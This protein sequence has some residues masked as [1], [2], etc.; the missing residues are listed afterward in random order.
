LEGLLFYWLKIM[1]LR[2]RLAGYFRDRDR[3][4]VL[5]LLAAVCMLYLPFLGSPFVFDDV[6]FFSGGKALQFAHAGFHFDL[7]WVSYATLGW[8]AQLFSDVLPHFFRL[9]NLLIHAANAILLFYFLR[10]L[11]TATIHEVKPSVIAWGGWFG[12]LLFAVNPVAVYATGY[13]VE[14]SIL[15]ATFFSL[16]MLLLYLRGLLTGQVRW[17]VLAVVAYFLAVFSKEHS[18]MMPAVLAALTIL[19][20]R[21][22][23][24]SPHMLWVTW[25]GFLSIAILIILRVKGIWGMPYEPMAASLFEQQRIGGG[26]PMLH[27]LSLLTQAG[28]YFKYLLLWLLPNPAWMS[29]DMREPFI[30]SLGA[31]QG[32]LKIACFILYGI[33]GA[34]LLFRGGIRGLMGF[35]LLYPWLQFLLEFSTIRVQEPFVLYRSYLWMPGLMLLV[36]LMV[37]KWPDRKIF[38]ALGVVAVIFAAASVNRLWVFADNYRLWNDA[39]RLLTDEHTPGA[40]RIFYNRGQAEET[41]GKL[42]DA[43]ADFK[44][45]VKISPQLAPVQFE[46]GWTYLVAGHYQEAAT[47]FDAAIADD[48]AYASAYY[49]KALSLSRQGKKKQAAILMAKSCELKHEMACLIMKGFAA[50]NQSKNRAVQHK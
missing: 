50:L 21:K 24:P 25:V 33:S 4:A 39:A 3:G 30:S 46:L 28:L 12:A 44:R 48:P 9:G 23:W 15:L 22:I 5:S 34:A 1:E 16:A 40:D 29:I 13:V 17:L 14:R 26:D 2:A 47:S 11:M 8:T 38:L 35:A 27:L 41:D 10:Q 49:G 43:I 42:D 6:P 18:V 36:T 32:W 37:T 19:L 7:R 45:A 20:R 31:W